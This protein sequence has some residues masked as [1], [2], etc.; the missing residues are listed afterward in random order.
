ML[1]RIEKEKDE[2][3]EALLHEDSCQALAEL[4]E[5][6]EVDHTT[7]SKRFKVLGMIQKQEH[8]VPYE[9]K[10]RNVE[11]RLFRREELLQR[12]KRKGFL[13]RIVTGD[14]KWMHYDNPTHK[15]S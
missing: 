11:R 13:H 14:E 1:W 9:L 12:Q 8:W 7:I 10:P 5:S 3:L 2:E 4:A 15:R 6:L